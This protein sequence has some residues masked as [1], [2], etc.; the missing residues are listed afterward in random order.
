M[1]N[2]LSI[3]LL[4]LC[5]SNAHAATYYL[6]ASG[7]NNTNDGLTAGA[8]LATLEYAVN[9]KA[10]AG[11]TIILLDGNHN[12][13]DSHVLTKNPASTITIQAQNAGAAHIVCSGSPGYAVNLASGKLAF[14]GIVFD[15]GTN[16]SAIL[17]N[18]TGVVDVSFTNCTLNA[19]NAT[20]QCLVVNT[21][22]AQQLTFTGCTFNA[23]NACKGFRGIG[24]TTA[25]AWTFT[26]C[27]FATTGNSIEC[28]TSINGITISGCTIT[29]TAAGSYGVKVTGQGVSNVSISNS[30]LTGEMKG[31]YI[32]SDVTAQQVATVTI[33]NADFVAVNETDATECVA[34]QIANASGVVISGCDGRGWAYGIK[35]QG[36]ITNIAVSNSMFQ[37]DEGIGGWIGG[38]TEAMTG[39]ITVT[40]SVFEGIGSVGK[41]LAFGNRIANATIDVTR[42]LCRDSAGGIGL[43]LVN[44]T[45]T[46]SAPWSNVRATVYDCFVDGSLTIGTG[47]DQVLIRSSTIVNSI[48]Q[49]ALEVRRGITG[50]T[51]TLVD[52]ILSNSPDT[53]GDFLVRFDGTQNC[54]LSKC[55]LISY[56]IAGKV[57]D[58]AENDTG[59]KVES[60]TVQGCSIVAPTGGKVYSFPVSNLPATPNIRINSNA[61]TLASKDATFGTIFGTACDGTLASAQTAWNSNAGTT[62]NDSATILGGR[63]GQYGKIRKHSIPGG[64]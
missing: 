53:S 36:L 10:A 54:T 22:N 6:A 7:G 47:H 32:G 57:L 31:C 62:G 21:R 16:A 49:N 58:S 46:E 11:D 33:S 15:S 19:T 2:T 51:V 35:A 20:G 5:M 23:T 4:L 18:T 9:T 39:T 43:R 48:D 12:D 55:S 42:T 27:T 63:K 28:L 56:G 17:L 50:A 13:A 41:G 59:Q 52:C 1:R 45:A 40:D 14:S 38:S 8:A 44:N 61:V 37:C 3:V 26:N 30:T 24:A 60:V 64:L 25:G 29:A 34:L